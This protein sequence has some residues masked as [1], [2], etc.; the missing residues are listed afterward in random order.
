M[1]SLGLDC[2]SGHKETKLEYLLCL[3]IGSIT[4]AGEDS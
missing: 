1:F 3:V 2:I 4:G